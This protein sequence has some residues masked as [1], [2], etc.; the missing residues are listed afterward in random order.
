MRGGGY[1][2]IVD[3]RVEEDINCDEFRTGRFGCGGVSEVEVFVGGCGVLYT[4]WRE[5]GEVE[6][7]EFG[8]G[9]A[10]VGV[11]GGRVEGFVVGLGGGADGGDAEESE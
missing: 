9:G 11:A 7:V 4:W 8:S 2:G 10:V 6:V 3:G 5:V 1:A